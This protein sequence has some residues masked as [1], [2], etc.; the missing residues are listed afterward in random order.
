MP[1]TI[2]A[3]DDLQTEVG[4]LPP[5]KSSLS[6]LFLLALPNW[7][8]PRK[9]HHPVL[10]ASVH[11]NSALATACDLFRPIFFSYQRP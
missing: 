11:R 2:I 4:P 3:G 7:V 5:P 8:A 6:R 10:C 9:G 1:G